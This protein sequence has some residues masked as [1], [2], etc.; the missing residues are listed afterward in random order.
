MHEIKNFTTTGYKSEFFKKYESEMP[1]DPR[2]ILASAEI[3]PLV[4]LFGI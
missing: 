4:K 3:N 2:T 1:F